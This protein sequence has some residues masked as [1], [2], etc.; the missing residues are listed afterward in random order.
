VQLAPQFAVVKVEVVVAD[1]GFVSIGAMKTP[2]AATSTATESR[3]RRSLITRIEMSRDPD[4]A[5]VGS[6]TRGSRVASLHPSQR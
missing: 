3:G 5:P 1:A 6:G 2:V 4:P